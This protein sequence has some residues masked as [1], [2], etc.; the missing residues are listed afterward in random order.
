MLDANI[1]R[2]IWTHTRKQQFWI[3]FVVALSMIPYFLSFNLPKQI[4]NGPIQGEGFATAD[5]TQVFMRFAP[6]LPGLG[7]TVLFPG[8][9]LDRVGTLFALSG[10]FLGLVIING[11][12]KYYINIYKGKLGERLLRRMRFTL[13]DNILRFPPAAFKRL[14]GAEISSMVKDEVEP[15]GGFTGDAF[16][17]PALLGGQA[18]TALA[19]IFVQSVP[20]G[21][22]TAALVSIQAFII[23]KMRRRLLVLGRE[24]QL[25]AR[26]LAGRVSEI[27][28]GIHTIHS[29]DTSNYERADITA[30]LGHIYRIRFDIYQWK[31]LVKFINNF[32]ASVTPFLFYSVGGYLALNGRLDIGQLVAVIGAYKDLP[33]PLKEL[34]DWDQNRQDVQVKYHQVI[35]QFAVDGIMETSL[36]DVSA[37]DA[38]GR[39]QPPLAAVNLGVIDESGG[40]GL[41]RVNFVLQ[42][43]QAVAIVGNSG[44]GGDILAEA[45]GRIVWPSSGKITAGADDLHR[46]PESVT[47]RQITYAAGESYF[48]FGTLRDNLL[49]GLKH[50]PVTAKT[51]ADQALVQ[52]T[53][54]LDEAARAGNPDLDMAAEWV[55]L[56]GYGAAGQD[57]LM[58]EVFAAIEAASLTRD[59]LDLALRSNVDPIAYAD[60]AAKTVAMRQ[61]LRDEL[62][63]QDLDD[64]IVPFEPGAYN[65]EATVIENLLFGNPRDSTLMAGAISTNAHFRA[66]LERRGMRDALFTM[67]TE[68]ARNAIELFADLPPDHPFFQQLSFMTA[69]DLPTYQMLLQKIDKGAQPPTEDEASLI[70]R[71]SFDYIEP[72]FRFGLLTPE[73]MTE[74]VDFRADFHANLPADLKDGIEQFDP[75]RY[76]TS[77]SLLD[78]MLF[79]RI[80]QKY[81]DGAERIFATVAGL[82]V[83]LG[84]HE[85]VLKVGLDFHVGAGGK[86]LTSA[87]RQKFSL[88]RALIRKSDFYLFNRPLSAI[89]ARSQEMIL[90][91]VLTHLRRD[92]RVPGIVWVVSQNA[93]ARAFDRVAVFDRGRLVEDGEYDELLKKNGIFK[94]MLSA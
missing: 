14:K 6:N 36:Q 39:L 3:L 75:D 76:M 84:L 68:I 12:F 72:R 26:E 32:L 33:G 35:S 65:P 30:R 80:S 87:Q 54:E 41:E 11:L 82:L 37:Q 92:G 15:L 70:I 48:F 50:A 74:I 69:D 71:L 91:N 78:N 66:V 27:V 62:V 49:Y 4:V 46:L 8:I 38:T 5:A 77:G 93:M 9:P 90:K 73:L 94:E 56:A 88:V 60:L 43:G 18:L 59:M 23:P 1:T 85:T 28:D 67:G 17:A 7:E 86:R 10:V 16:V 34:I 81:R 19:F 53:W 47:G 42:P 2:Y 25:T 22:I 29:Y 89:D 40:T 52:R 31:F 13:V 64:L 58:A 24:R 57:G 55:D 21:L 61:Q 63:R 79:G 20:L 45:L 83:P 51:Y 44:A